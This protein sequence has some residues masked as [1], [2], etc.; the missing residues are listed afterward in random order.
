VEGGEVDGHVDPEV[1]GDPGGL[2]VELGVGVVHPRDEKGGDLEPEAGL[3]TQVAQR[4]ED[5]SELAGAGVAIEVLV[6]GL[7]VHAASIWA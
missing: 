2:G 3:V 6:E 1:L 7:E 4:G 5:G